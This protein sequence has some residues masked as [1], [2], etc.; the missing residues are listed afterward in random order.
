MKKI[1]NILLIVAVFIST[2]AINVN[3]QVANG[4]GTDTQ[5]GLAYSIEGIRVFVR[6]DE[7]LKDFTSSADSSKLWEKNI[8]SDITI[9]P[10]P[11]QIYTM[12]KGQQL[13]TVKLNV[14]GG[15]AKLKEVLEAKVKELSGSLSGGTGENYF[16]SISVI[17]KLTTLPNGT[18]HI[19]D[20]DYKNVFNTALKSSDVTTANS[21][22]GLQQMIYTEIYNKTQQSFSDPNGATMTYD[23]TKVATSRGLDIPL[24]DEYMLFENENITA[25]LE[26]YR[27]M[28]HDIS[29]LEGSPFFLEDVDLNNDSDNDDQSTPQKADKTYISSQK[30][31]VPN[32]ASNN[33]ARLLFGSSILMIGSSIILFQ[34]RKKKE[35]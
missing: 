35:N 25:G 22:P 5:T 9:N 16:C 34:L 21:D 15:E 12:K 8:D 14:E 30:V 18:T 24:F 28:V 31:D 13:I 19:G 3:A 10:S 4:T 1:R 33:T 26:K 23:S 2:F 11:A 6:N 17:Y 27:F 20:Y 32:T 29:N 7:G